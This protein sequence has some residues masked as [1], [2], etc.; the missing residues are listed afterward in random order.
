APTP[1]S[2]DDG[3]P[4]TDD[5]CDLTSGC[6]NTPNNNNTCTLTDTCMQNPVCNNGTCTGT[7]VQDG[8][9]CND[10]SMCTGTGPGGTGDTCTGGVGGGPAVNGDDNTA[11][12]ADS[13]NTAS[14]CVHTVIDCND[15]NACTADSCNTASG[16]VNAPLPN[17]TTCDDGSACTTGD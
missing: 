9:A 13:C 16:C 10:N 2:C 15:N 12:T 8:T 1:I 5:T 4:C 11:C 3:N 14:G 7:P 6:V 17:G